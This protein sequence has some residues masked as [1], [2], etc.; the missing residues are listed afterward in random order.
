ML[1]KTRLIHIVLLLTASLFLLTSTG[2][3][4]K[5]AY[6]E[7]LGPT[8][9]EYNTAASALDAKM[10]AL[11]AD[12]ALFTDPTWQSETSAV[13]SNWK[14]ASEAL[15]KLP[16][17]EQQFTALNDLVQEMAAKSIQAADTYNAA[18]TAGDITKMNDGNAFLTRV[19]ELLPQINAEINRLSK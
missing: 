1:T 16:Q 12:N 3:S 5:N 18:I 11:T 6:A 14:G 10:S 9:D 7:A 15:T 19:N 8:I 17:P 4:A 13:I 2:C